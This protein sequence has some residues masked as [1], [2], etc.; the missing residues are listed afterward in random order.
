MEYNFRTKRY[1]PGQRN[2]CQSTS[3]YGDS[4]NDFTEE[5]VFRNLVKYAGGITSVSQYI[6]DCVPSHMQNEF[7][8]WLKRRPEKMSVY[9]KRHNPIYIGP[10]LKK[11]SLC[12]EH[13][14][15]NGCSRPNCSHFHICKFYLNGI[16]KRGVR[17]WKGHKLQ[18]NEQNKQ[19]IENLGFEGFSDKEI[20]TV[21]LCRYPQV[22]RTETC[23]RGEDCPY[24]H[25]CYNFI[26]NRCQDD[27]CERG[28]SFETPHNKWVLKVYRMERWPNEKFSLLKTLINMPRKQ[29]DIRYSEENTQQGYSTDDM[30]DEETKPQIKPIIEPKSNVFKGNNRCKINSIIHRS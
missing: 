12:V 18:D 23:P 20:L 5:D 30:T 26:V 3:S 4:E 15:K 17:C 6:A 9:I 1:V 7:K 24:L 27:D 10:L 14:G 28:H 25:I 13:I 8:Q 2:R 11:A 19:P 29:K 21:I 22:C 16:C